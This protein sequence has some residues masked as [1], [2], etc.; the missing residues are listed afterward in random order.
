M[1][2]C[3]KLYVTVDKDEHG[4]LEVFAHLGKS[5]QCGAAQTEALCRAVSIGLR[6]EVDVKAYIKQLSGIRC[7]SPG[8]DGEDLVLSCADGIAKA[9]QVEVN[10]DKPQRNV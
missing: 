2:G 8:M 10:S 7:P 5:G 6:S 1:T 9:L 4:F 3:G